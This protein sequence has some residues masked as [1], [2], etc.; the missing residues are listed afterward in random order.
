[1]LIFNIITDWSSNYHISI[2]KFRKYSNS[3]ALFSLLGLSLLGLL[4]LNNLVWNLEVRI[5]Q[6]SQ[7]NLVVGIGVSGLF[8]SFQSRKE[9]TIFNLESSVLG[10]LQ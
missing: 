3:I 2:T 8:W 4:Q 9:Q 7:Y 1:M 10:A 5:W 6:Q